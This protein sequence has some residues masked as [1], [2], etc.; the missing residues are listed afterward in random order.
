MKRTET[1]PGALPATLLLA[2]TL[3][4]GCV[5]PPPLLPTG[6][7]LAAPEG[8][9]PTPPA[10]PTPPPAEA[11]RMGPVPYSG[12]LPPGDPVQQHPPQRPLTPEL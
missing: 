2:L 10:P 8:P 6:E 4:A 3:A 9:K 7:L 12:A 5:P 1:R 11:E